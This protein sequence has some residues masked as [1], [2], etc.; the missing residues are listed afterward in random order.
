[1][2]KIEV[3][4]SFV[5]NVDRCAFVGKPQGTQNAFTLIELL[6]VIAIIA[7]LAAMLLPALSKAKAKAQ[8]INCVNNLKQLALANRMYCDDN[9]DSMAQPN[10]DTGSDGPPGWLY[11]LRAA[12]LPAGAPAG[13]I[14]NPY[15]IPY[16]RNNGSAANETGLWFKYNHNGKAY[17]CP[18][19]IQSKSFTGSSGAAGTRKNKLS[20]YV[21]NGAV[22]N[23]SP[24]PVGGSWPATMK[25]TSVWSPLCYL[26]WEPDEGANPD[27]SIFNDGSN[28]PTINNEGIGKMHS[29]HGGNAMALDG[30]VD[31][32]TET[33]FK[34]YINKGTGP[35]PGGKTLILWS[36]GNANG[37][38]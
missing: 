10:W 34:Q 35:G 21:Q 1:M 33:Q 11:S 5:K 20:S 8:G 38:R 13:S 2:K 23:F 6:V 22:I 37:Y 3:K 15:D 28:D 9:N 16:W 25:M 27:G 12:D 18:V 36:N 19:D 30:H 32:V 29:K 31:F 17:L 24:N 26:N 4:R 14:P 7:I